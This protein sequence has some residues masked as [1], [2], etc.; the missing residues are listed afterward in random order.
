M[1]EFAGKDCDHSRSSTGGDQS[2]YHELYTNQVMQEQFKLGNDL[3]W[4]DEDDFVAFFWREARC[5]QSALPQPKTSRWAMVER[6][7]D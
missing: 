4:T 2:V 3:L 1:M 7:A 6:V 5:A